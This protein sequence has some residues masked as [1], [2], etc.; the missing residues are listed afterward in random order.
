[1][2]SNPECPESSRSVMRAYIS[3]LE[4]MLEQNSD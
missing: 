2:D 4:W 1:M 3:A